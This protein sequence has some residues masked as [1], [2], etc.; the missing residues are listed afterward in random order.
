MRK[1][2]N[3]AT[4]HAARRP[5]A[6]RRRAAKLCGYAVGLALAALARPAAAD[7]V[8]VTGLLFGGV[9]PGAGGAEFIVCNT[10]HRCS[11]AAV[12][13]NGSIVR[14]YLPRF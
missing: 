13:Q 7:P 9:A 10:P 8:L 2:I 12:R 3:D 11:A 5:A 6:P 1:A 4:T 14:D